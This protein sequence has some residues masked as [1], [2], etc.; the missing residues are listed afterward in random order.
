[1][2]HVQSSHHC[3]SLH[4]QQH[5]LHLTLQTSHVNVLIC[6]LHSNSTILYWNHIHNSHTRTRTRTHTQLFYG[7]MDFVRYFP[8]ELVP[9][10]T[11]TRSHLSWSSIV[12]YLLH[13]SN[14][15]HS[16]LPLQSM[17]LTV[18]FHNISPSFLM[19]LFFTKSFQSLSLLIRS[20]SGGFI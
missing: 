20:S 8:G 12:P 11:F 4:H 9:E 17:R 18:F 5:C 2:V 16:I 3:V 15:M 13:S 1:M 19:P 10:Q 6:Y 14:T 7:S